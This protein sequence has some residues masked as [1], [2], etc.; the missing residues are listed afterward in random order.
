MACYRLHDSCGVLNLH[1]IPG[2]LSGVLSIIMCV[3]ASE[4]QYGPSLYL[5][6]PDLNYKYTMFIYIVCDFWY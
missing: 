2:V 1:G 3:V 6:G 4:E 5:V